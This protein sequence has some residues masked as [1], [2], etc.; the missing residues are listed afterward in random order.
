MATNCQDRLRLPLEG[1][2][3]P[4]FE[5]SSGLQVATGYMRIVIGGRGP[6]IEFLPGHL[7]WDS[8]HMLDE[9][10]Y[11]TEHQWTDRVYYV[12]WRTNDQSNERRLSN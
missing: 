6:H 2:G 10:K 1:N 9:K 5:T 3:N 4:R 12:E 8:L 7:V 11:R